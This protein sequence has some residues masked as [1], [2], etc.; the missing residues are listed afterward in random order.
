MERQRW[1][2]ALARLD[3]LVIVRVRVQW[4]RPSSL[5]RGNDWR[6]AYATMATTAPIHRPDIWQRARALPGS[7]RTLLVIALGAGAA[8]ALWVAT[9]R[10]LTVQ[11]EGVPVE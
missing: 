2:T 1:G 5:I 10:T 3:A 11:V 9:A 7:I 8:W 6:R 4:V